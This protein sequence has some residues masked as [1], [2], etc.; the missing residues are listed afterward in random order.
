MKPQASN[1]TP[2]S[3]AVQ[4]LIWWIL[5]GTI[6]CGLVMIYFFLGRRPSTQPAGTSAAAVIDYVAIG[7]LVLSSV[8]RW[9]WFPRIMKMQQAFPIFI[10][11]LALAESTGIMGI[12]LSKEAL[13]FT[14]LGALGIVQWMPLFAGKYQ[15]TEPQPR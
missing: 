14:L 15:A 1:Q 12:F 6:L 9:L 2:N 7:P 4:V 13:I 3:Q 5:W 11:G 10:A 8:I